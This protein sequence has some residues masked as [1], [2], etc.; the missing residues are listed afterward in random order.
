M[1]AEKDGIITGHAIALQEKTHKISLLEQ[2]VAKMDTEKATRD[3]ALSEANAFRERKEEGN[4]REN[5][6]PR[7]G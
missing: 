5:Y 4:E 7:K 2:Q 3:T 1:I 6:E